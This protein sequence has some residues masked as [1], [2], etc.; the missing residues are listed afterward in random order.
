MA[1]HA[2][3]PRPGDGLVRA[4]VVLFLLGLAAIAAIFLP[5][6]VDLVRHGARYAQDNRHERGVPLN[7]ATFLACVG[8][9][10][11]LA[12]LVRQARASRRR[13]S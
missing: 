6:A 1:K 8:F 10:V 7:L 13:G 2:E 11:A 9:G 4:G 3:P 12:G 5:F